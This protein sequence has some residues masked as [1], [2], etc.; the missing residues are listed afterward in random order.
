[1]PRGNFLSYTCAQ[2]IVSTWGIPSREAWRAYV[3][4]NKPRLKA[5]GIPCLPEIYYLSDDAKHSRYRYAEILSKSEADIGRPQRWKGWKAW[6]GVKNRPR[7]VYV[8][9]TAFLQWLRDTGLTSKKGYEAWRRDNRADPLRQ[10]LPSSPETVYQGFSWRTA[11]AK[12]AVSPGNRA[13]QYAPFYEVKRAVRELVKREGLRKKENWLSYMREH[14]EWLEQHRCPMFPS[15]V[16]A[17]DAHWRGWRDFL[18]VD[19]RPTGRYKAE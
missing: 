6:L 11:F 13:Q 18:N 1:M 10:R 14:P 12:R 2:A 17:Y 16:A 7:K 9:K 5:L 19:T 3:R 15:H 8:P 4:K